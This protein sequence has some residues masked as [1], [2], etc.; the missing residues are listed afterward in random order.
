MSFVFLASAVAFWLFGL[1]VATAFVV[2]IWRARMTP[3]PSPRMRLL[4]CACIAIAAYGGAFAM[5]V[6]VTPMIGLVLP[7][8]ERT[9]TVT[10]TYTGRF[11]AKYSSNDR[12]IGYIV[13]DGTSFI[14]N[15]DNAPDPVPGDVVRFAYHEGENEIVRL[16]VVR[17]ASAR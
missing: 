14:T 4:L 3:Q 12:T 16:A 8:R 2:L 17:H 1:A 13:V 9:G 5:L 7:L 10:R 15:A 11:D 6:T